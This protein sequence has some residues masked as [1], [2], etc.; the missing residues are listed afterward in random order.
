[1][2]LST[3]FLT[4]CRRSRET[5]ENWPG[6]THSVPHGPL[7]LVVSLLAGRRGGGGERSEA[8]LRTNFKGSMNYDP[9][10]SDLT[11]QME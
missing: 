3:S 7:R 9:F 1:M 10:N 8:L 11:E 2:P 6:A 5:C 4:L